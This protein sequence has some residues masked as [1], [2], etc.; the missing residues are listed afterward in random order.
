MTPLAKLIQRR[1]FSKKVEPVKS[2]EEQ[3]QRARFVQLST[4]GKSKKWEVMEKSTE[5][6][7]NVPIQTRF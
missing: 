2:N 7:T 4:D 6:D 3:V 1:F 5:N